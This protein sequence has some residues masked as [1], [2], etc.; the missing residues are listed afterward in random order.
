MKNMPDKFTGNREQITLFILGQ[1]DADKLWDISEHKEKRSLDSNAYFHVL[2]DKLRQKLNI[3]MARCK[4]HLI[5]DYGQIEYIEEGIPMVYKTNA[6]EEYMME[7]ETL[8]SKCVKV[9]EENG[10]N[11]YFYRIYRGSHTYNSAEMAALIRGT[12]EECKAQDI[13]TATPEELQRMQ[14]LWESRYGKEHNAN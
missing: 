2:C 9:T 4:N 7:L 11:V 1:Q 8:H 5:A 12:V 3:S 13:P 6:P 10:K 14:Q